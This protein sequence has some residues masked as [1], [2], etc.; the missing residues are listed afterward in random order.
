MSIESGSKSAEAVL[1]E[2]ARTHQ[3][4][5]ALAKDADSP[6]VAPEGLKP[7]FGLSKGVTLN[8]D[9]SVRDDV[10][11][12][13][14]SRHQLKQKL[15]EE[16]GMTPEMLEQQLEDMYQKGLQQGQLEGH[17]ELEQEL[18]TEAKAQGH[19]EGFQQGIEEGQQQ[20]LEQGQQ[21]IRNQLQAIEQ[22][23]LSMAD[24]ARLLSERQMVEVAELIERLLIEVVA[25]ELKL[26][27]E[28]ILE[29]VQNAVSLLNSDDIGRVRVYV[30]SSDM[31]WLEPLR[32][33]QKIPLSFHSDD[34]LTPGGC[35]VEA[36]QGEVYATLESRLT[37]CI[38]QFRGSLLD[39]PERTEPSD[40]SPLYQIG[41]EMPAPV[42]PDHSSAETDSYGDAGAAHKN[43]SAPSKEPPDV[44][45]ESFQFQ[46]SAAAAE[47]L[48]AWGGLG[49]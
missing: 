30:H 49:Q 36:D 24:G 46:P 22:L 16:I 27:P 26:A 42:E 29:L 13:W 19:E 28:H 4:P 5:D 34:Q 15:V 38:E 18:R 9:S 12:V 20:G 14:G 47:G 31:H 35:R 32:Q 21:D 11:T 41:N 8:T 6:V 39:R 1:A 25:G 10:Y 40:F 17:T 43:S 37:D 7:L 48:G 44:Q 45:T 3:F 23:K 2:S 33:D